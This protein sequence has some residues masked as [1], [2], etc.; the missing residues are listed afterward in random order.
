MGSQFICSL[1]TQEY[2]VVLEVVDHGKR[3]DFRSFLNQHLRG[4][5]GQKLRNRDYGIPADGI[6]THGKGNG[7]ISKMLQEQVAI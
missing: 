3:S 2:Y 1:S 7:P 6:D 4:T 5:L